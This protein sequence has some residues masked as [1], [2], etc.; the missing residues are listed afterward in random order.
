M[1]YD[2]IYNL[3]RTN[4]TIKLLN[5]DNAP[6]IISF[7][8]RT[9]KEKNR[10]SLPEVEIISILDDH[11]YFLNQ[12]EI[13]Y[14]G[15]AKSYLSDWTKDGYLRKYYE[16]GDDPFYDLTTA[17]ETTL[18][19]I[20]ELS[21]AEFI[22]TESRLKLLF[23]ILR[24]LSSKSN[25]DYY[26]R[27]KEL[28][29]EKERIELEIENAKKGSF[30][31]LDDTQIKERYFNAEETARRLLSD[32]R[33]VEQNFRE[34]DKDFR[35]KII[36]TSK[37]KGKVLDEL[38]QQQDYLWHTDQG[39][40]F[41]AFWEFLLSPTKQDELKELLKEVLNLDAVKQLKKEK[42]TLPRIKGNLLDA[43]EK[44][45]RS[46]GS[47]LEQLRKYVEHHS[48][49]EEKQIYENITELLK[50][51]SE[52]GVEEKSTFLEIDSLIKLDFIQDRPLYQPPVKL[53]FNK[54]ALEEGV[55]TS[56]NAILFDQ[57]SINTEELKQNIRNALKLK[58]SITLQE[59][60]REYS[61][62]KGVAEVI[63]YV[64][65]ASKDKRHNYEDETTEE[66]LIENSKTGKVFKIVLPKITFNK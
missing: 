20:E 38:F 31:I 46:T 27:I 7:I 24:E 41:K 56:D 2:S 17:T 28:E 50:F 8:Y 54:Q 43:G 39:K 6:L 15:T 34:L 60:I 45:H 25:T 37:V 62:Q 12:S 55:S 32:F 64:E 48:F 58:S 9:F 42:G 1:N 57:F 3:L 65:I 18:R 21:K 40:S 16:S 49:F 29:K 22:G 14:S 36:T 33:E 5:A 23:D 26:T 11:L 35:M 4:I 13:I 51:I 66:L 19:W 59:L 44:V 30:L 61:I 47:L 52:H 63:A 10:Q 53:K